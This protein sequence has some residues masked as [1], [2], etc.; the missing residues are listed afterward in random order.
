VSGGHGRRIFGGRGKR[1][2]R[3]RGGKRGKKGG[4][5]S[6]RIS[7]LA[8]L[9]FTNLGVGSDHDGLRILILYYII[10]LIGFILYIFRPFRHLTSDL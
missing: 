5:E 3:E 2:A 9:G 8:G 4:S 7:D 1:E 10:L 6:L